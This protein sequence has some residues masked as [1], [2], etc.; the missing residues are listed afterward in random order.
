MQLWFRVILYLLLSQVFEDSV[1]IT[2]TASIVCSDDQ[3]RNEVGLWLSRF[4]ILPCHIPPCFGSTY[5]LMYL[6]NAVKIKCNDLKRWLPF[7]AVL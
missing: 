1:L 5:Q 4:V 2:G 7:E 6:S 3:Q